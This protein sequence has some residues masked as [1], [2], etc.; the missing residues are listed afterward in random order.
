[1]LP[2]K[3]QRF[4]RYALPLVLIGLLAGCA[5]ITAS[6][7]PNQTEPPAAT[8]IESTTTDEHAR[9]LILDARN[10]DSINVSI[11]I[12]SYS[13]NSSPV[14]NETVPMEA[15][16]TRDYTDYLEEGATYEVIV[17]TPTDTQRHVLRSNQ[18]LRF[19]IKDTGTIE[20]EMEI[21]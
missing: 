20:R 19:V 14:V 6:P 11:Q 15:Y 4:V 9:H 2:E 16:E 7:T 10:L 13:N 21:D 8:T 18:A 5:G 12:T 3:F 1:M 17:E